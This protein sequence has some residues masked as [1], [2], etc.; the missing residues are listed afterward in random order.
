MLPTP[1]P[2]NDTSRPQ[3]SARYGPAVPPP[4][5]THLSELAA[6][7][8]FSPEVL[9]ANRAGHV[10]NQQAADMAAG[11]KKLAGCLFLLGLPVFVLIGSYTLRGFIQTSSS[12]R[13]QS[14]LLCAFWS[15][16]FL[17]FVIVL[18]WWALRPR[19]FRSERVLTA[20]GIVSKKKEAA[21]RSGTVYTIRVGQEEWRYGDPIG[22]R[23]YDA[24]TE[25][26]A[27]RAYYTSKAHQILS[28]EPG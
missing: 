28:I 16:A 4:E 1:D 13:A 17:I 27:Y 15:P 20:A 7:F 22:K 21:W 8:E 18:A 5:L 14:V 23:Y 11:T 19:D 9:P 2:T 6:A 26:A 25:G 3:D 12:D 24:L 10:T